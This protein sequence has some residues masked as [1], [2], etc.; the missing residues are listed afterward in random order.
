MSQ[1]EALDS[2]QAAASPIPKTSGRVVAELRIKRADSDIREGKRTY[3]IESFFLAANTAQKATF[4]AIFANA[5][6][7]ED[8][9]HTARK[10]LQDSGALTM[11]ERTIDD[12]ADK[13]TRVIGRLTI[14]P[15][16]KQAFTALVTASTKRTF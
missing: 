5:N 9:L 6:C 1:T 4:E 2:V 14:T 8:D 7:S 10:L 12:L 11:A 15:A 13:A 3:L 16:S